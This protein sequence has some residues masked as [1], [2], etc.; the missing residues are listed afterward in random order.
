MTGQNGIL[1]ADL[2]VYID[3][4]VNMAQLKSSKGSVLV[5]MGMVMPILTLFIACALDFGHML[6]QYMMLGQLASVGARLASEVSALESADGSQFV[7]LAS[8]CRDGGSL[9]TCPARQFLVQERLNNLLSKYPLKLSN[10]HISSSFKAL[11]ASQPDPGKLQNSVSVQIS[12]E[13]NGF[14][15]FFKNI[16]LSAGARAEYLPL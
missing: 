15:P 16:E 7:D 9:S 10:V 6:T 8:S 3:L 2:T 5:E 14:L 4:S 11:D 13:F 12:A 1:V